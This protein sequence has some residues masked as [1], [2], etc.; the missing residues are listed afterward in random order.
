MSTFPHLLLWH[1]RLYRTA[2]GVPRQEGVE[3]GTRDPRK[4]SCS[5][6]ADMHVHGHVHRYAT[7]FNFRIL[8]YRPRGRPDAGQANP[9]ILPRVVFLK[10]PTLTKSPDLGRPL[11]LRT[12][13]PADLYMSL[14]GICS[15]GGRSNHKMSTTSNNPSHRD[16]A[17][18]DTVRRDMYTCS[19]GSDTRK[20]QISA[21]NG[22]ETQ[23]KC[24]NPDTPPQEASEPFLRKLPTKLINSSS[25]V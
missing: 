11:R 9:S 16:H 8:P 23:M 19:A 17:N 2:A 1:F 20:S 21:Q 12:F 7:P 14:D 13:I 4:A 18:Q 5:R 24:L 25:F 6:H 10:Y 15:E 3:S 22:V